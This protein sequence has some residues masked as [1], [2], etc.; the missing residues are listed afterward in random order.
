MRVLALLLILVNVCFWF[1][2][3]Y[4]DVPESLPVAGPTASA[5]APPP[6]VL[7]HE[8]PDAAQQAAAITSQ[9]SCVSVG[10]FVEDD[11]SQAAAKRL[12][13][14]GFTTTERKT[15]GD[16]FAGYWVNL[17]S[18]ATKADA[19]QA[20]A[21][22]RANGVAD[23]FVMTD[24]ATPN[25]ISLGLFAEQ[26]HAEQR[27]DAIAKLGFTPQLQ[28]RMRRGQVYWLDVA[29]QEPGQLIDPAVL[30]PEVAGISRLETHACPAVSQTATSTSSSESQS[31]PSAAA[32]AKK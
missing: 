19:E 4:V 11:E 28:N 26:T 1:W 20:L 10:P 23:A 22:L 27:R 15:E 17:S 8:R 14:A 31:T 9:L 30:Q 7:A 16:V 25:V 2:A 12:E 21:R 3:R 18:F 32:V 24:A 13:N 6:L 5:K 29:L